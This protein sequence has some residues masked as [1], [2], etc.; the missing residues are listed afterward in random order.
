LEEALDLSF[1]RLLVMMMMNIFIK[2]SRSYWK[3]ST[4]L[5]TEGKIVETGNFEIRGI[6]QEYSISLLIFCIRLI[7]LTQHLN[8]LNKGYEENTTKTKVSHLLYR[9]HLQLIGE[10]EEELQKQMQVVRTFSGDTHKEFGLDSC[11]NIVLKRGKLLQSQNLI[12]DFNREIQELE[13]VKICK[14]LRIEEVRAYVYN[15]N[16]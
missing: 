1:D 15:V 9:G 11:A 13:K 10:T 3:T 2:K 4:R 14:C 6:L 7:P 16:K 5:H 12:L 8:K